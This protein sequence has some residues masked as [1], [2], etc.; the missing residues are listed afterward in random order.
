MGEPDPVLI[1]IACASTSIALKMYVQR[2]T[3]QSHTQ[4]RGLHE[5]IDSHDQEQ[6]DHRKLR[7]ADATLAPS[8][9]TAPS[10]GSEVPTDRMHLR[11]SIGTAGRRN[12]STIRAAAANHPAKMLMLAHTGTE[13]SLTAPQG[14]RSKALEL[15]FTLTSAAST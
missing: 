4:G 1:W 9:D 10:I 13:C 7:S 12:N 6:G 3:R 11:S 14:R 2:S 8:P 15:R 5:Q